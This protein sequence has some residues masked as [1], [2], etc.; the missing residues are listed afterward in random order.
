MAAIDKVVMKYE[1]NGV[2]VHVVGLNER[3]EQLVKKLA[4]YN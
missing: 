3:S 2:K 4:S 1:Q